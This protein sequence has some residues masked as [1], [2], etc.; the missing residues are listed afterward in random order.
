ML[1]ARRRVP[2][3]KSH[4]EETIDNVRYLVQ[5]GGSTVAAMS[6]DASIRQVGN[7]IRTTIKGG[8]SGQ[9]SVAILTVI[10]DAGRVLDFRCAIRVSDVTEPT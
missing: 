5:R 10:T 8:T 4:E 3:N 2:Y 7:M 1:L 9:N 6:D